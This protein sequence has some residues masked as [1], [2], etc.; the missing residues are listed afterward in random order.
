M[1]MD[2]D[3]EADTHTQEVGA[4]CSSSI[5]FPRQPLLRCQRERSSTAVRRNDVLPELCV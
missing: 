5:N 2:I 3:V 4:S 1:C